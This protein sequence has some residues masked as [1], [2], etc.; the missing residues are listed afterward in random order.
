MAMASIYYVVKIQSAAANLQ[1]NRHERKQ[2][3]NLWR[4]TIP[5]GN[6]HGNNG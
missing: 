4:N 1:R 2:Q 3:T 5:V 6:E